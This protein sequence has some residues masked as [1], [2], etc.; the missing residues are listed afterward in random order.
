MS[1]NHNHP[2]ESSEPLWDADDPEG[3][4][5]AYA[6][7]LHS[8]ARAMFLHD[9]Y[10]A[11][12]MFFFTTEGLMGIGPVEDDRDSFLVRLKA[13]M[14]KEGVFGVVHI[15]ESW[16]YFGKQPND[17]TSKQIKM[18]EM[19]VSELKDEDKTETLVVM[20][21]T[22]DGYRKTWISEIRRNGKNVSLEAAAEF[23]SFSGRFGNL[24]G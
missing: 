22:R 3:S 16:T 14:R 21:Q 20:A 12:L 2:A 24:F 15:A 6:E 18:G 11:E 10:H 1:T 13:M 23:D 4:M 9:K 17:H 19:R 7:H 8:K 5:T